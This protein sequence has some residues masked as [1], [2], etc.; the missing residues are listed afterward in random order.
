MENTKF[1]HQWWIY[2]IRKSNVDYRDISNKYVMIGI[3]D[4]WNLGTNDEI[5]KKYKNEKFFFTKFNPSIEENKDGNVIYLGESID[6]YNNNLHIRNVMMLLFF[7][8]IL[9]RKIKKK[10]MIFSRMEVV[11]IIKV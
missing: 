6:F 11:I 8:I 7:L 1:I 9:M 5:R 3:F 2:S 4:I 10:R